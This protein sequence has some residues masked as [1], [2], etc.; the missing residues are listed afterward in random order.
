MK[1]DGVKGRYEKTGGLLLRKMCS[2]IR[3][4]ASCELP[5][6][7]HGDLGQ[8]FDGGTCRYLEVDYQQVKT[9]VLAGDSD[10]QVLPWCME[11][12]RRLNDEHIVIFDSFMSNRGWRDDETDAYIPAMINEIGL[13]DDGSMQTDFDLIEIDEGRWSPDGGRAAWT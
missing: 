4:H 8:A 11:N 10:D 12:G 6:D 3:L 13:P 5:A 2:K 9:R 1:T 7:L